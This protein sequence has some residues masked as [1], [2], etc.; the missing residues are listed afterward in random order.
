[1]ARPLD[2]L[3][4]AHLHLHFTGAMRHPT[5]VELAGEYGASLP[6]ALVSEWPP[7][8]SATDERG[9]FRFQRLYDIARSLVRTEADVRRLLLEAAADERAEGSGWLEIQVDPSGYAA[10]FGGLIPAVELVLDAAAQAAAQAGTGIGVIIAANRTKHPL[11]ARTLARLA[12][13]FA[14]HGVTGFGLSSDERRGAAPEFARAFGIARRAG[15]LSVP[16]GGELSGP[17]SVRACLVELAADRIGHGV[18]AAAD[19]PLLAAIAAAGVTLE[20]CPA[21]N[22]ALGV[23]ARPADVPLTRLL[24]AGIPVALGADD[25]LLFGSRLTA[26]YQIA[27][28]AHGLSDPELAALARMSVHASAAP[29]QIRARLLAGIDAWLAAPDCGAPPPAPLTRQA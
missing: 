20:V 29:P 7:R 28:H 15:L 5:L 23:A 2:T 19:P 18:A 6:D 11:E 8:L 27:R 13:R 9:W 3:P 24:E 26:Q 12:A 4:K 14:G 22:V 21:S 17:A 25:P 1:M 16:H 10:R